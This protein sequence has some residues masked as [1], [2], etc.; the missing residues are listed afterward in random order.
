MRVISLWAGLALL[1]LS[2]AHAQPLFK[3]YSVTGDAVLFALSSASDQRSAWKAVGQNF[4]GFSIVGFEPCSERLTV[5]KGGVR[6]ELGLPRAVVRKAG[7]PG[8]SFDFRQASRRLELA[9]RLVRAGDLSLAELLKRYDEMLME[10]SASGGS[11]ALGWRIEALIARIEAMATEQSSLLLAEAQWI[12]RMSPN[13]P[14][15]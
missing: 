4:E 1:G 12:E 10:F 15:R 13:V 14:P 3:G 7:A 6:A 11:P 2:C 9:E 5:E 8:A